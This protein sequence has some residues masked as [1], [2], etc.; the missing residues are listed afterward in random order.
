MCSDGKD[1][2]VLFDVP[3][4]AEPVLRL[5][6]CKVMLP[7][8]LDSLMAVCMPC[9]VAG[10]PAFAVQVTDGDARVLITAVGPN[11]EWGMIME[12]VAVEEDEE[13]PLQQKLG[14]MP[15]RVFVNSC[16]LRGMFAW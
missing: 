6:K 2:V 12:K 9:I 5:K 14:A 8:E 1:L 7:R 3:S 16:T 13:T 4:G 11:S 10:L 15:I